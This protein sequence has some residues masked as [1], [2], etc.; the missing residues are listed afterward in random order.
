MEPARQNIVN[1]SENSEARH[2]RKT[3]IDHVR[4]PS[5]MIGQSKLDSL[6]ISICDTGRRTF[7]FGSTTAVPV[8]GHLQ[9]ATLQV[10]GCDSNVHAGHT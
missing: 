4:V 2:D 9:K 6:A 1:Q 5:P 7:I 3:H 10:T 8:P